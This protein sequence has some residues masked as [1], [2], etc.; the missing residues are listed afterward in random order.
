MIN[1]L[2]IYKTSKACTL[3][4]FLLAGV[5]ACIAIIFTDFNSISHEVLKYSFYILTV[6]SFISF[7]ISRLTKKSYIEN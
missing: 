6:L 4:L 3:I 1:N 7:I 5:G 2:A